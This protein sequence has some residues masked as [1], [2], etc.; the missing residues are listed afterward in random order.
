M[1]SSDGFG[2]IMSRW[3]PPGASYTVWSCRHFVLGPWTEETTIPSE[4]ESTS[5]ID[6]GPTSVCTFYRIEIK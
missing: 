5:W 2:R 3:L 6:P 4:G 1:S